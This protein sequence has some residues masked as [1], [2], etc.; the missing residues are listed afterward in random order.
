LH[1][2]DSSLGRQNR[3]T[4]AAPFSHITQ[5]EPLYSAEEIYGSFRNPAKQYDMREILARIVDGSE[6]REYREGYGETV[7]CAMRASAAGRRIVATEKH[8]RDGARLGPKA[9]RIG[10]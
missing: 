6:F 1:R 10:A 9:H 4:G 3:A 7:L 2:T 5:R 8:V